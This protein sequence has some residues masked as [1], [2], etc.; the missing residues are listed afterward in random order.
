M[1]TLSEKVNFIKKIFGQ[2][3][4]TKNEKNI[5]VGCPYCLNKR[6]DKRKFAIKLDDFKCHCWVCGYAAKSL[7]FTLKLKFPNFVNE[8]VNEFHPEVQKHNNIEITQDNEKIILPHDFSMLA[9]DIERKDPEFLAAINYL[10]RR[11]K[12]T[13]N[14]LWL[15]KFGISSDFRW[16]NRIIIPSFDVNGNLNH[17]VARAISNK[18]IPKYDMPENQVNSLIFNELYVDF[19]KPVIIC[20]GAFD[21]INC[22]SNAIPLLGSD[23][24]EESTLFEKII[25]N[26]SKIILALDEDMRHT[27]TP[28]LAKLLTK[29]GLDVSIA[30]VK[31]DPGSTN[32][33]VMSKII[34]SAQD[35]SW[36]TEAR[37][38]LQKMNTLLRV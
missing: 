35:Y 13:P 8:Y 25:L 21:A 15:Y 14:Q 20:E 31:N 23:L 34:S 11:R 17:F 9:L 2:Y 7:L 28:K 33:D 12:I 38:R 3:D 36:K 1:K 4:L 37:R 16:K 6:H 27:K 5:S 24:N 10:I 19:Q 22:G 26:K 32:I 30:N 18:M 29:Y